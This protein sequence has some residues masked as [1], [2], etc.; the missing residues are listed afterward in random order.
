MWVFTPGREISPTPVHIVPDLQA[1]TAE[2]IS[3]DGR[4]LQRLAA[5]DG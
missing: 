1:M 3:T 4:L 5:A 2:W